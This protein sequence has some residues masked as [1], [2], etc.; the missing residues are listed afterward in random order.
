MGFAGA[1]MRFARVMVKITKK[2]WPMGGGGG[3]D[4]RIPPLA[5]PLGRGP[6]SC[7]LFQ[8]PIVHN[9]ALLVAKVMTN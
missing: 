9:P 5:M 1:R 6:I 4:P 3:S 8:A 7:C 2:F